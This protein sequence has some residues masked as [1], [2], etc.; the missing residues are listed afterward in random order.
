MKLNNLQLI[1]ILNALDEQAENTDFGFLEVYHSRLRE[2][3]EMHL[4]Y[5][6]D[7]NSELGSL[8]ADIESQYST[9]D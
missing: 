7:E 4:Q 3:I 6:P 9:K 2:D 8:R 5:E 1:L